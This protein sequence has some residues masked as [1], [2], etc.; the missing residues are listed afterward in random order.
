MY[1]WGAKAAVN[2]EHD[3][4]AIV[5]SSVTTPEVV[6][7]FTIEFLEMEELYL[8]LKWDDTMVKIPISGE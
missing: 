8:V 6:E 1:G 3:A 7:M 5:V 2:R 4:L